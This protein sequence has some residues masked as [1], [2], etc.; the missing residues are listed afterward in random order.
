MICGSVAHALYGLQVDALGQDAFEVLRLVRSVQNSLA[1]IHRIPPVVL[2]FIPDYYRELDVDRNLIALTHVCRS[3]RVTFISRSSLWTHLDFE[4]TDKTHTYIQRSRSSPLEITF[5]GFPDEDADSL[6]SPI[7]PHLHRLKSLT[8]D[9]D[10]PGVLRYLRCH[11]PLLEK[12]DIR[13]ADKHGVVLNAALFNGDLSMLRELRL[14]RVTPHP[15]WK[16]LANLR[17]LHLEFPFQRQGTIQT[18][19][20]LESAPL[21]HTVVLWDRIRNST[22]ASPGRIVHLPHL[23]SLHISA[24][25]SSS[26][27]LRHLHIPTGAELT[28]EFHCKL[29][30]SLLLDYLPETS[31]N[32]DN[33]SHIT[34]INLLFSSEQK[35]ALLYGPSGSLRVVAWCKDLLSSL[36]PT[37]DPTILQSLSPSILSTTQKLVISGYGNPRPCKAGGCPI[38][39]KLS[40]MENLRTLTLIGC[41]NQP[42]ILALDPGL[43]AYNRVPCLNMKN[44]VLCVGVLGI[45]DIASVFSMAKHRVLKGAKLSSI[46]FVDP[47]GVTSKEEVSKL[48]EY[49]ACV[50]YKV[51]EC[52]IPPWD[53]ISGGSCH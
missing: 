17:V 24:S 3:W 22:D 37:I 31:Q 51:N 15:S 11:T 14:S 52:D 47:E 4:N 26:F 42:F 19:H 28:S 50:E 45:F 29:D 46:T 2:S 13:I 35:S 25:S 32:F 33:L 18:L 49:V 8:I 9:A 44:L 27:L 6:F 23:K 39:G 40:S 53:D 30:K 1:P 38:F 12:L 36:S 41:D 48:K 21:L 43:N 10:T 20:L 5:R 34:G 16:G 7:I